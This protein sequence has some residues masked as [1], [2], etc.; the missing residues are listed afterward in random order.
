MLQRLVPATETRTIGSLVFVA[1][2]ISLLSSCGWNGGDH[3]APS[4]RT[5]GGSSADLLIS[6][7]QLPALMSSAS[8][9]QADLL[10]DGRLTFSE[11]EN[12]VFG[13]V[14]CEEAAGFKIL[15]YPEP[16]KPGRPGPELTARGEYQYV[17]VAAD[18]ADRSSL[19]A[20]LSD[21]EN[22]YVSVLRALWA[23]HVAPTPADMQAA[24][25]EIARCLRAHGIKVP[26]HPS[27][28]ELMKLAFPP[29]GIPYAPRPEQPYVG[30]ASEVA[31]RLALPGYLGQ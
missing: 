28:E 8:R 24:R 4:Q 9:Y 15:A 19:A 7:G 20:A 29:D 5:K 10:A 26:S 12:A 6:Q 16:G 11:Y 30:C 27:G 22:E 13:A 14:R 1:F 2:A 25:D 3:T 18:D 23:D 21:C 31:G 17:Q